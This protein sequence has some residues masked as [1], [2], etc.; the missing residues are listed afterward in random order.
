MRRRLGIIAVMMLLP[1]WAHAQSKTGTTVGTFLAIEPSARIAG[2]G[3]AGVAFGDAVDAVYYNPAAIGNLDKRSLSFTHSSWLAGI[4]YDYVA[5]ALPLGHLGNA[6][7]S[8]TAL[9]SGDMDVRTVDQPLGTGERFSVEDVAIGLGYGRRVAARFSVGLQVNYL[10]ETIW[11]SSL[12]AL[13]FNV[14]TLYYVSKNGLHIGSSISNWGTQAGFS[15]RDLR[16]TYD[17]DPSRYGDNGS[18]PASAFTGDFGLPVLF[19]AGIGMPWEWSSQV[20][21][22]WEVDAFHPADN[23]ESVSAGGE[24]MLRN[25]LALR[26]GYQN[27]FLEDSELGLT[28]GAGIQGQLEN[29]DYRFNYA[30][31]DQGRLGDTHRVSLALSF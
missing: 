18:L 1:G 25:T 15:G 4:T 6:F 17:A 28:L 23:D 14:G 29:W 20:R 27:L 11:N 5:G 13:T 8:V 30:W 3:N 10:Q 24:L 26:I 19:R 16:V 12:G 7:T 22:Q 31:A 9:H 2:M 21:G